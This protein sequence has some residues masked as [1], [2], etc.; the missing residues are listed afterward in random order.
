MCVH[1]V[2]VNSYVLVVSLCLCACVWVGVCLFEELGNKLFDHT[3]QISQSCYTMSYYDCTMYYIPTL[4]L[5]SNYEM[6]VPGSTPLIMC[7]SPNITGCYGLI[8]CS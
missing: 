1:A 3:S 6:S 7:L 4:G 2:C 8:I 5:P